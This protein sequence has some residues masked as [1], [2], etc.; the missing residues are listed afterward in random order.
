MQIDQF[1]RSIG[2]EQLPPKR[3]AKYRLRD[4]Y[5]HDLEQAAGAAPTIQPGDHGFALIYDFEDGRVMIMAQ[6]DSGNAV[7][8]ATAYVVRSNPRI[9]N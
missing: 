9:S 1:L 7:C 2:A 4:T 3:D 8:G 5:L 6:P